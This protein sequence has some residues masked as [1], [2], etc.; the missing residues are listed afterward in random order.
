METSR[1]VQTELHHER[2]DIERARKKGREEREK[3]AKRPKRP[4]VNHERSQQEQM[5]KLEGLY[6]NEDL[7]EGKRSS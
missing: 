3:R 7:G 4:R 6:R 5:V 1:S 2:R